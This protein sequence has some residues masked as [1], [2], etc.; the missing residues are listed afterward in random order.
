MVAEEKLEYTKEH[1]KKIFKIAKQIKS[2]VIGGCWKG[3]SLRC[4]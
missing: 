1:G 3:V 4:H 2:G